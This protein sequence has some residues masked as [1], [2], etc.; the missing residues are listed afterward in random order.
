MD[1]ADDVLD[2]PRRPFN[3][4][5]GRFQERRNTC[6][7][8]TPGPG[9]YATPLGPRRL[10]NVHGMHAATPDIEAAWPLTTPTKTKI[11]TATSAVEL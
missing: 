7:C 9:R 5:P 4:S 3:F 8:A 2:D 11:T 10:L 1:T 6:A